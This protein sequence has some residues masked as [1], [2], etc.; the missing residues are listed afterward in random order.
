[1]ASHIGLL[2]AM[3]FMLPQGP[4]QEDKDRGQSRPSRQSLLT[5]AGPKN[6]REGRRSCCRKMMEEQ[7]PRPLG[8]ACERVSKELFKWT[9]LCNTQSPAPNHVPKGN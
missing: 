4:G 2:A 8:L 1:M 3:A 9:L 6:Q 5:K 7:R